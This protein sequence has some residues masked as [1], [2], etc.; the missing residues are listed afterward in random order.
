MANVLQILV[1]EVRE[2]FTQLVPNLPVNVLRQDDAAGVA[3]SLEPRRDIYG[4]AHQVAVAFL[5]DVSD[6]NSNAKNDLAVAGNARVA[7]GHPALHFD[8]ASK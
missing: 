7:F 8:G 3:G 6:M 1:A 2:L 5:D 4:V